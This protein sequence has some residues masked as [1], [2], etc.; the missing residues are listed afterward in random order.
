M[1]ELGLSKASSGIEVHHLTGVFKRGEAPLYKKSS[2][3]LGIRFRGESKRGE[4][5]LNI[6][7]PE[8]GV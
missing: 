3:F 4:A 1:T 7:S 6:I 5:S 2:F 8:Q